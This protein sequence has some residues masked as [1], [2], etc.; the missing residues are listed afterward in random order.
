MFFIANIL[1]KGCKQFKQLCHKFQPLKLTGH[2]NGL[3]LLNF[4]KHWVVFEH[5]QTCYITLLFKIKFTLPK[6]RL[7]YFHYSGLE[8]Q[9]EVLLLSRRINFIGMSVNPTSQLYKSS[10][11]FGGHTRVQWDGQGQFRGVL[12]YHLGIFLYFYIATW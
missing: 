9:T 5:I 3:F 2:R 1:S 6:Y 8:Y 4:C 7:K 10:D 11:Y 12:A